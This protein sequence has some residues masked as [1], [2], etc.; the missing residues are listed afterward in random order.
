MDIFFYLSS[1][2]FLG[3][4]LGANDAANVFG[5]AVGTRMISFRSAA[6]ICSLFLILGAVL[7][8]AGTTHT[9]G[10][11]GAVN[12]LPG[13]FTVA[14]A[15]AVTLLAMTKMRVPVS[16]S[17]AIVGAIIGWNFYASVSTDTQ[18]LGTIV[19]TW[20]ICPILA[21]AVAAL[22]FVL[23][24]AA[25]KVVEIHLLALDS[26]NRIGLIVAGAF[27]AYSLGANNIAN[28][29]GVFIA[30]NPFHD[31]DI[32]AG[33]TVTATQQLFL[34]G[35][36]AI[37]VGVATYSRQ[38]MAT[39]GSGLLRLSP[40]AALVVV[41]AQSIVLFVFA[42]ERLEL[43][44]ARNGLPTIPLVPV[45]SSQ[46]VVGAIIGVGLVKGGRG[47]RFNMLG[48]IAGG[49]IATPILAGVIAFVALFFMDNVFDQQ[50][51]R[52][53]G[54]RLDSVIV[55]ELVAEGV[56][57]EQ[58]EPLIDRYQGDRARLAQSLR[59]ISG[60]DRAQVEEVMR[61]AELDSFY[62]DPVV[63]HLDLDRQW[64]TQNQI[65]AVADITGR[66]FAHRWCFEA[67]LADSTADWRPRPATV[68]NKA[69]NR[70]L[71]RKRD[72]LVRLFRVESPGAQ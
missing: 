42:S 13:A 68:L 34:L 26:Y 27:G 43:F 17:Q 24:R 4:S 7:G 22:L 21:A 16:T 12:T 59:R 61:W 44:L 62:L 47:I 6:T 63:I 41:V 39:V 69:W 48:G 49:W 50:V 66:S 56:S 30:D 33:L 37:S 38:V 9:L 45:S 58:L 18:T 14:L 19:T 15:A 1:G 52:N 10:K 67:A 65:A 54:Y 64:L 40:L 25:L 11:L 2:L 3:W 53:V 57:P 60:W 23:L 20:V 8:G 72:Y 46:A 28:V 71:Q 70:E 36:V 51:S 32:V 31:V 5:T 35:A 55:T 29:M